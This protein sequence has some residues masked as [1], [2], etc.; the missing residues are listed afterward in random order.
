MKPIC[1]KCKRFYRV[2]RNGYYFVEGMPRVNGALPGTQEPALWQPYK[3]WVGDLW[4]CEGC[5]HETVSGV[6]QRPIAE[7]Y[8]ADFDAK[9]ALSGTDLQINDC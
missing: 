5:G 9:V 7:H 3:L 4:Q 1:V 8:E 2:K 6:A